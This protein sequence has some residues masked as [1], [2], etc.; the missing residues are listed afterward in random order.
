MR[1][2]KLRWHK[3]CEGQS[4]HVALKF[5][6]ANTTQI[7]VKQYGGRI[8]VQCLQFLLYI[9]RIDYFQMNNCLIQ[10]KKCKTCVYICMWGNKK[11]TI[12]YVCHTWLLNSSTCG[13]LQKEW[14]RDF[15]SN[16]R[17]GCL[18]D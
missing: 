18:G 11:R 9:V 13:H 15:L 14:E 4:K 16:H 5:V 7:N 10:T 6:V 2:F 17:A 3:Y 8:H 12:F 1:L